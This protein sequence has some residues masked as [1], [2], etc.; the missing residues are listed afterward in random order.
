MT[1]EQLQH[2]F[3]TEEIELLK[4]NTL[5]TKHNDQWSFSNALFQ[6]HLAAL[7]LMNIP[8][9]DIISL[10]SVG[11]KIKKGK[12]KMDTNYLILVVITG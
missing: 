4:H 9:E 1:N 7:T 3:R 5:L 12:N 6:E 10:I 2:L 11:N 8:Y